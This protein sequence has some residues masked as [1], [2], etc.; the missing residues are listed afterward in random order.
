MAYEEE[1]EEEVEAEEGKK[2]KRKQRKGG[3]IEGK[4]EKE[5]LGRIND[6]SRLRENPGLVPYM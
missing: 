3:E 4:R 6:S 1:Q 2:R 5:L